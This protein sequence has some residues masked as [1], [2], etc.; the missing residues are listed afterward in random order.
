MGA[1]AAPGCVGG[2]GGGWLGAWR[3]GWL[4]E[5]LRGVALGWEEGEGLGDVGEWLD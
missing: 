1:G 4:L 3:G 5:C 2:S